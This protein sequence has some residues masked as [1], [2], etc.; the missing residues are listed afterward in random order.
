VT[1][2]D[3]SSPPPLLEAVDVS[4]TFTI[5][6]GLFRPDRTFT[7]VDKVSVRLEHGEVLGIVGE[8]GCGKTT[9]S[10]MIMGMLRPTSG[11]ILINGRSA[12]Q[13]SRLARARVMQ[14]VFQDPYSSLNPRRTMQE[15][16][17]QP[18]DIH[19][20]GTKE[21][22]NAKVGEMLRIVGLPTRVAYAYPS[23]LSGGQRQRVAIARALV[24]RPSIVVC[25]EPTSALDVSV[26][27]QIINLL[28]ELRR[29]FSVSF[30]FISHNLS[31]V[32]HFS[33]NVAVMN[34]GRVVEYGP[35]EAIFRSP[36]NAYT[37]MLISSAL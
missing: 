20:V 35:S 1:T 23:Q 5:S 10:K 30:I 14:P 13:L 12:D 27:A 33:D 26:Q 32:R 17:R 28:M 6:Q 21:E 18:L 8:S 31:V 2:M 7:A 3:M 37:R 4:R 29:E 22:R 9:L 11:R 36:E 16:I 25:D 19:G 24:L 34:K 15:I